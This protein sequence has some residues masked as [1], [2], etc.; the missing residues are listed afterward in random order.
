MTSWVAALQIIIGL[1]DAVYSARKAPWC[2]GG[3]PLYNGAVI[4][5]PCLPRRLTVGQW[6]EREKGERL[7]HF[8]EERKL[9]GNTFR[10]RK[11]LCSLM[12]Q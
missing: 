6:N 11:L 8:W 5:K 4:Y 7:L 12:L 10:S 9:L 1:K 2:Q 3:L